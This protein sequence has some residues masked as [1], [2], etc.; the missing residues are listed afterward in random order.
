MFF[1]GPEIILDVLN[2]VIGEITN[3]KKQ[4]I[5]SLLF[6]TCELQIGIVIDKCFGNRGE[7]RM[8]LAKKFIDIGFCFP[9]YS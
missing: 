6:E 7:S 9:I 5:F 1:D 3:I 8:I 4:G 2:L